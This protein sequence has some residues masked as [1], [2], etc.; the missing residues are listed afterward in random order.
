MSGKHPKR[1]RE[2]HLRDLPTCEKE[3]LMNFPEKIP[4][5]S[6]HALFP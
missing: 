1:R 3:E 5:C 4:G 2:N 6:T